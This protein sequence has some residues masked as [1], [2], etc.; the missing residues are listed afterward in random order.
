M[1]RI[2][3]IS[4]IANPHDLQARAHGFAIAGAI[5]AARGVAIKSITPKTITTKS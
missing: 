2:P 4:S 5:G 1:A 3:E